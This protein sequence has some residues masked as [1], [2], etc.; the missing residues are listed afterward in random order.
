MDYTYCYK[1]CEKGKTEAN[2]IL[3]DSESVSDAA[4]DFN[5]F[6]E[7]CFNICPCKDKVLAAINKGN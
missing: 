6:V 7:E 5:Y 4:I 2:K 3:A 1:Y